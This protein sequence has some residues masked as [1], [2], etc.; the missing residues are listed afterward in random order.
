MEVTSRFGIVGANGCSPL[1]RD[2][3]VIQNLVSSSYRFLLPPGEGQDEGVKKQKP[4]FFIS[5]P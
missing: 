3:S 4:P 5:S 1:R 2:I